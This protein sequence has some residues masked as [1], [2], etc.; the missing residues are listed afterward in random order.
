MPGSGSEKEQSLLKPSKYLKSVVLLSVLI[1]GTCIT[2]AQ[3]NK[4][5]DRVGGIR[6]GA[7]AA[8][9]MKDGSSPDTSN[10][11][12]SFYVGYFRDNK[13]SHILYFDSG[14]EYFQNGIDYSGDSKRVLHTLS[15]KT[16]ELGQEYSVICNKSLLRSKFFIS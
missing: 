10:F 7:H 14:L 15:G 16:D 8:P 11:L 12:N 9:M 2:H 1:I 3:G 5:K 4:S 13:I 6:F